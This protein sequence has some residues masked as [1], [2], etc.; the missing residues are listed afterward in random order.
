MREKERLEKKHSKQRSR[1]SNKVTQSK[2]EVDKIEGKG[3][4]NTMRKRLSKKEQEKSKVRE[5]ERNRDTESGR[6]I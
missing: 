1:E 5:K 4:R 6:Y 3:E 2:R